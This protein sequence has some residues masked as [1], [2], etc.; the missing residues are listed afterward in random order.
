M[1]INVNLRGW[2]D[3]SL[4]D[5]RKIWFPLQIAMYEKLHDCDFKFDVKLDWH[6]DFVYDPVDIH[7]IATRC[8][9]VHYKD[10]KPI[11]R[12]MSEYTFSFQ[13]PQFTKAYVYKYALKAIDYAIERT[14][15]ETYNEKRNID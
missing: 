1:R 4:G 5:V 10:N 7:V 6:T 11:E 12:S 14:Y 15:K 9:S 3:Y 8:Y 13:V 2:A